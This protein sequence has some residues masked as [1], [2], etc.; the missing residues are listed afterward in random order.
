[1]GVV[2]ASIA[3]EEIDNSRINTI[4]AHT[5]RTNVETTAS[6]LR[7]VEPTMLVM[8][9]MVTV[10]AITR[11]VVDALLSIRKQFAEA[12]TRAVASLKLDSSWA[13]SQRSD[14]A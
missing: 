5:T 3:A 2:V 1:M 13:S 4:A 9:P 11:I 12:A 14:R 8:D 10:V 7:A 6:S